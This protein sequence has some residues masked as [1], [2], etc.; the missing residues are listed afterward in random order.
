MSTSYCGGLG[1]LGGFCCAPPRAA[2]PVISKPVIS[3]P[4]AEFPPPVRMGLYFVSPQTVRPLVLP[5][6]IERKSPAR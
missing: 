6:L 5:L 2:K 4:T 1:G 3:L